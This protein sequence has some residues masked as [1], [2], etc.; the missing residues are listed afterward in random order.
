[1]ASDSNAASL[2][3][4]PNVERLAGGMLIISQGAATLVLGE[5]DADLLRIAV[6][7]VFFSA[8]TSVLAKKE[9]AGNASFVAAAVAVAWTAYAAYTGGAEAILLE[10]PLLAV[11][12][13]TLAYH[14]SIRSGE[15]ESDV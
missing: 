11:F 7:F 10:T 12:G 8:G 4:N 2:P 14:S 3:F 5:I 9:A 6:I 13:A 1:M 15:G